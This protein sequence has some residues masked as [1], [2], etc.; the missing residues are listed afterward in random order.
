MIRDARPVIAASGE[1]V[2]IVR[3]L[4]AWLAARARGR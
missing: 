3:E 2:P 1:G 4:D